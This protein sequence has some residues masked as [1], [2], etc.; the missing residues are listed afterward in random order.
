MNR[1]TGDV[2]VTGRFSSALA[3]FGGEVLANAGSVPESGEPSDVLLV[4]L[5]GT[6]D[7]P[8]TPPPYRHAPPRP[9]PATQTGAA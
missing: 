5:S 8:S 7:V 9:R 1:L 2:F 6:G 3:T 4:K